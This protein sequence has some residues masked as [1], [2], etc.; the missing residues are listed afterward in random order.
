SSRLPHS[1]C[2]FATSRSVAA[3][4]VDSQFIS[5]IIVAEN[6]TTQQDDPSQGGLTAK[7]Q[8]YIGR[9]LTSQVIRDITM[10]EKAIMGSDNPV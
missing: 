9:P 7:A 10:G 8:R 4:V 3:G 1:R 5:Q 2:S 6:T